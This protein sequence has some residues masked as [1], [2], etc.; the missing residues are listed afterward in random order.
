[1]RKIFVF[2]AAIISFSFQGR[3]QDSTAT[4]FHIAVPSGGFLYN[5]EFTSPIQKGY[6]L[7]GVYSNPQVVFKNIT[8][9][10]AGGIHLL[11]YNGEGRWNITRPFLQLQY[12]PL[13]RLNII[14]GRLQARDNHKLPDILY[15]KERQI[16]QQAQEGLQFRWQDT[17]TFADLWIDWEHFISAGDS[18]QERFVLGSS[19]TLSLPGNFKLILRGIAAHRG[20]E[21]N[22]GVA[23]VQTLLNGQAGISWQAWRHQNNNLTFSFSTFGFYNASPKVT[24]AYQQGYLVQAGSRFRFRKWDIG[25]SY[26]HGSDFIS[27][28]GNPLYQSI[29]KA[30]PGRKFSQR[31]MLHGKVMYCKSIGEQLTFH[32]GGEVWQHLQ[33]QEL[34][35][36]Y[37]F[38]LTIKPAWKAAI[39]W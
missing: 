21:I 6:T 12:Q 2:F 35:Y 15:H 11:K 28:R 39:P 25:A 13:S 16:T 7:P 8:W 1:M 3:A 36:R 4:A 9:T 19:N 34:D 31:Q 5:N 17:H 30:Y 32:L 10:L 20:G 37:W 18:A 27:A 38:S 23:Q 29:S 33:L 26:L 14:L 24:L 22:K